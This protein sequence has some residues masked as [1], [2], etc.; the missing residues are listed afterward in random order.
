MNLSHMVLTCILVLAVVVSFWLW[1]LAGGS[2]R[3]RHGRQ[4]I[5]PL[6]CWI[7][8]M[9]IGALWLGAAAYRD[10]GWPQGLGYMLQLLALPE[11]YLARSWRA[12][13]FEWIIVGSAM[14]AVSSFFW[15]ALLIWVMDRRSR[16]VNP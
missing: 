15:A 12:K 4:E 2:R 8:T 10:P 1:R 9:R 5:W 11:T 14:L 13:P 6:A 7:G 3:Q 16:K